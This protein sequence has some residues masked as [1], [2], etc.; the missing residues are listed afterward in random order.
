MSIQ[1][2]SSRKTCANIQPLGR[3]KDDL[4]QFGLQLNNTYTYYL[5]NP[6]LENLRSACLTTQ[7]HRNQLMHRIA[8]GCRPC[9]DGRGMA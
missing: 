9:F 7:R 8:A 5:A 4:L 6:K 1:N 3:A 2:Q